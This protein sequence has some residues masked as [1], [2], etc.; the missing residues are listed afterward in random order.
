M[1]FTTLARIV[2]HVQVQ[3]SGASRIFH[4]MNAFLACF[5]LQFDQSTQICDG[6][7]STASATLNAAAADDEQEGNGGS[8]AQ[9]MDA[10]EFSRSVAHSLHP[11]A[12]LPPMATHSAKSETEACL[13]ENKTSVE[14][15]SDKSVGED[16]NGGN[17]DGEV[18]NDG[19]NFFQ[20]FI[21]FVRAPFQG[22]Q[23]LDVSGNS[24]EGVLNVDDRVEAMYSPKSRTWKNATVV[25][26]PLVGDPMIWFDGYEDAVRIPLERIRK[27]KLPDPANRTFIVSAVKTTY[28]KAL[29]LLNNEASRS[30]LALSANFDGVSINRKCNILEVH[31]RDRKNDVQV[32]AANELVAALRQA[33]VKLKVSKQ[34]IA[35]ALVEELWE[36]P[37]LKNVAEDARVFVCRPKRGT[38]ATSTDVPALVRLVGDATS[39]MATVQDYLSEKYEIVEHL[40]GNDSVGK[41]DSTTS[42]SSL[43]LGIARELQWDELKL[44]EVVGEGSFGQVKNP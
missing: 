22:V 9:Y 2:F 38:P 16:G 32:Q 33:E 11:A 35:R 10:P 18:S 1:N 4:A 36:D 41:S 31:V 15:E 29:W 30:K 21:E 12:A 42:F 25:R 43:P 14:R 40:G 17:N 19:G 6:S 39:D 28:E 13:S 23:D 7:G 20:A 44:M 3:L 34:S 8:N 37:D 26:I 27:L 24:A 5:G